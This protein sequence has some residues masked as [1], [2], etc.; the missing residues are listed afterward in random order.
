M[1]GYSFD[2][3]AIG[4]KSSDKLQTEKPCSGLGS[5]KNELEKKEIGDREEEKGQ[6]SK[7]NSET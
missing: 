3:H 4:S 7:A 1:S 5:N 6:R 2:Q